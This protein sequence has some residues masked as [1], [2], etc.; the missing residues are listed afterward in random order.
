MKSPSVVTSGLSSEPVSV[1]PTNDSVPAAGA[2]A[3]IT[4][5]I[6]EVVELLP[7]LSVTTARYA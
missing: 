5:S 1:R 4:T 3:S 2:A 7:A 6:V